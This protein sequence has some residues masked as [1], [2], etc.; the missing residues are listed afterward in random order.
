[1]CGEVTKAPIKEADK[2][3]IETFDFGMAVRKMKN[4][5]RVA[6]LGWNTTKRFLQIWKPGC[7]ESKHSQPYIQ[8]FILE[9]NETDPDR[10]D[11]IPWGPCPADLL[12]EDWFVVGPDYKF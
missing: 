11:V 5:D 1:M 8:H 9:P 6:R 4:Y 2:K 10:A 3:K 12:A 7:F